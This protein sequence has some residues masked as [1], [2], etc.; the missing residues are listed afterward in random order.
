MKLFKIFLS[1][2]LVVGAIMLVSLFFPNS[3]HVD[4]RVKIAKPV[5]SVF[6]FMADLR[7]WEKWSLWN[8]ETD[9]TLKVFYG[10]RSDSIGGRQYFQG[11]TLG[12][13]RF[14]VTGYDKNNSL[15]YDLYMNKGQITAGGTFKFVVLDANT[16]ELHWIDS[17]HVGY[18]PIFRFMMPNKIKSTEK[19]FDEGLLRIQQAIE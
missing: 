4:R 1:F 17:G 12:S 13:G 19:A 2:F 10:K 15:Q 9:T 14:L 7:N 16:T 3:Y 11:E 6:N 8:K 18:N 5:D